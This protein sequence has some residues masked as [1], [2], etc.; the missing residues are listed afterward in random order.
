[1]PGDRKR[2]PEP[3]PGDAR[4]VEAGPAL[5]GLR[6]DRALS[7]AFP[8]LSRSRIQALIEGGHVLVNGAAAKPS[9][10]VRALDRLSICVPRAA[11]SDLVPEARDLRILFEDEHLLVVSKPAGVVV[12]PGAGITEGTLAA[13]LLGHCGT[14]SQIGG[15][16]R[17]GIV[18]RLDKGTS[19]LLVVAKNDLS[20][21]ALSAQFKSRT[22]TKVYAAICFGLPK[23][24]RG[25]ITTPIARDPRNRQ[26]MAVVTGGRNAHTDYDTVERLGVASSLRVTLHTG[27][28]H[29]IRVHLSSIGCPLVGDPTYGA[30]ALAARTPPG[31][32]D[33]VA[34][35]ERPALHAEI[36][37]FI[38]P[39]S[40]AA[41]RFEEPWPDDL[42]NLR[43]R[44]RDASARSDGGR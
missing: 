34:G 9:A 26:R 22:V 8:E 33:I 27:R 39:V 18:H 32:R 17:P 10:K 36:L 5:V 15:V 44:L 2:P 4:V 41:L 21:R 7:D 20:H 43:Q 3:D 28:T 25:S 19:G 13:A 6:L 14:L 11:A 23:P 40:G 35:F 29:Q 42:E 31:V 1:L 16:T 24:A 12:H 37:G 30:S 38:H